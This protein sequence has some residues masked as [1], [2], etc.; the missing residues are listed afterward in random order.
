MT[1]NGRFFFRH[2]PFG[3]PSVP[4]RLQGRTV[5]EFTE[6]LSGASRHMDDT[7]AKQEDHDARLHVAPR[8]LP[9]AGITLNIS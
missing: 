9:T 1:P 5:S 4:E 7:L 2:L 6:A 8:R 3:V